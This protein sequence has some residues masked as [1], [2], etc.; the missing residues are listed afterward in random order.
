ML[1]TVPTVSSPVVAYGPALGEIRRLRLATID[2][3][4]A[5]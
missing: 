1:S 2:A 4:A 5:Q 3:V